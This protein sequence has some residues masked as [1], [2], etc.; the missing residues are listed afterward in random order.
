MTAEVV[1][2]V[3]GR[4]MAAAD[5]AM[6]ARLRRERVQELAALREA[7]ELEREAGVMA[8]RLGV[9]EPSRSVL[10]RSAAAL[11]YDIGE[12]DEAERLAYVAMAGSPPEFVKQELRELL[13][14]VGASQHL[15]VS[16]VTLQPG[17]F[18]FVVVGPAVGHGFIPYELYDERVK[19]L[20]ATLFRTGERLLQRPYRKSGR[21]PRDVRSELPMM[22]SAARSS[23][24]A[25]TFRVGMPMEQLF[26]AESLATRVVLEVVKGLRLLGEGQDEALEEVIPDVAYRRSFVASAKALAPDGEQVT[27]VG[28]TLPVELGAEPFMLTRT[29]EEMP[30]P[31]EVPDVESTSVAVGAELRNVR[32]VLLAVDDRSGKGEIALVPEGGRGSIT[33]RVPDG[34]DDIVDGLWRKVVEVTGHQVDA[35]L[36]LVDIRAVE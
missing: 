9:A 31:V 30:Y 28:F 19:S 29:A 16:G 13:Q 20:Q 26:P 4:A 3:H 11:A 2:S 27:G 15:K 25:I 12:L 17:D 18:Q 24:F 1:A 14:N 6:L 5:R 23:S 22:L 32:G 33:V 21:R 8:D 35:A 7:F 36:E 10:L 34:L